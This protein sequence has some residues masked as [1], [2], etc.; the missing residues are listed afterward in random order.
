[1]P[2]EIKTPGLDFGALIAFVAPGFV[3]LLA[4]AYQLPSVATLI[5]EASKA[6]QN[7]GIFLFALV[8]SLA[9]GLAVSGLRSLFID[10]AMNAVL[11]R[12]G[13]KDPE[14][15]WKTFSLENLTKLLTVRDN[16]Y[17]YYQFYSNMAVAM[18]LWAEARTWSSL[19]GESK[20]SQLQ[21]WVVILSS[22]VMLLAAGRQLKQYYEAKSVIAA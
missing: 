10:L 12:F 1:M 14:I 9:V 8:A 22:L 6:E 5:E 2:D 16:F 4:L 7:V 18:L 21:W 11:K 20:L 13:V 17:R 19:P 15:Q 3:G